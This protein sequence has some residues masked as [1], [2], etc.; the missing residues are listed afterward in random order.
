MSLWRAAVSPSTW[1]KDSQASAFSYWE[2]IGRCGRCCPRGSS[3]ARWKR[4]RSSSTARLAL[5]KLSRTYGPAMRGEEG[6]ETAR[7]Q[8]GGV[9][10][11]V[12]FSIVLLWRCQF[13]HVHAV[14]SN[15]INDCICYG[16]IWPLI[17]EAINRQATASK[18]CDGTD[19]G[20]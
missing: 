9:L 18:R 1:L 2:W 4:P 14:R 19:G 15:K 16:Q 20:K 10:L 3:R 8:L 13:R 5:R 17:I 7:R 12:H 11:E 6:L